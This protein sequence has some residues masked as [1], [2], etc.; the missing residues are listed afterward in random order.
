MNFPREV[1]LSHSSLDLQF[2]DILARVVRNHGVPVW[3]SPTNIV[4]AQQWHDQIGAALQQCDWFIVV[5]SPDAVRSI[6]VKREVLFALQQE[7]FE[8]RI[9]PITYIDCDYE[10]LSRTLSLFQM[11]DFRSEVEEGYRALL[12]I[13]GLGY[14][15]E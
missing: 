14:Q 3:Y 10:R 13:W 9:V 6:W 15:R 12:R 7:R 8:N 5:L 2:V 1:F 4:G 11:V